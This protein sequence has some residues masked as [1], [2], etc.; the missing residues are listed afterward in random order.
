MPD[1]TKEIVIIRMDCPTCIAT[2]EKSVMKVPGVRKAQGNYIKKT[3]RVT[4]DEATPLAAIEKAIEDV[5][6]QV[7]YKKYPSTLSKLRGLFSRGESKAIAAISDME[8]EEK[9]LRSPRPVAVLFSG[10]GCPSCRVL[11]PKINA[12]AE[13][14]AGRVDFYEMDVTNTEAWKEYHVMGIP[15]VVVFRGGKPAERFGAV[16]RVD[17]LEKALA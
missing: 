1:V 17:E 9:V 14:Q 4:Y 12:L 8:F 15:T 2:L 7:A 13:R 3:L 16:L 6:Y 11:K 10:E 5:G